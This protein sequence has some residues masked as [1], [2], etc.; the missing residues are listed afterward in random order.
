MTAEKSSMSNVETLT[1]A[2]EITEY[3]Q[4]VVVND[5]KVYNSHI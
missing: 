5:A 2:W 4:I 1:H 3:L